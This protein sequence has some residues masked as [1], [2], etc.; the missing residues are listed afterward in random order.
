LYLWPFCHCSNPIGKNS[1]W[2]VCIVMPDLD[3][4]WNFILEKFSFDENVFIFYLLWPPNVN[5]SLNT[6]IF[7]NFVHL[8][9]I[10]VPRT[11][12][13][14]K[15]ISSI[16]QERK[17][18]LSHVNNSVSCLSIVTLFRQKALKMKHVTCIIHYDVD[19]IC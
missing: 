5:R 13:M 2:Q 1:R 18:G 7:K 19:Y 6:V 4:V 17:H 12:Y 11:F 14:K 9:K 8:I 10:T 15:K 16:K 3:S